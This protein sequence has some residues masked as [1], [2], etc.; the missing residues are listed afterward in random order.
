MS[1]KPVALLGVIVTILLIVAVRTSAQAQYTKDPEVAK[2]CMID[3]WQDGY[4]YWLLVEYQQQYTPEDYDKWFWLV[5]NSHA[6]ATVTLRGWYWQDTE[7]QKWP[8]PYYET[9]PSNS[10]F[11]DFLTVIYSTTFMI[12]RSWYDIPLPVPESDV[13]L[14]YTDIYDRFGRELCSSLSCGR[15][16]MDSP[17]VIMPPGGDLTSPGYA[18][19]NPYKQNEKSYLPGMM[20][21]YP[22]P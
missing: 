8:V 1:K 18:C 2:I 16:L 13:K 6:Q 14:I 12:P 5:R 15:V 20:Q 10:P 17:Y 22:G 7:V 3:W 9:R 11:N 19:P 4:F 21:A